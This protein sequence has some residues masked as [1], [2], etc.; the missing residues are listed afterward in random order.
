M[1]NIFVVSI[2]H[3]NSQPSNTLPKCTLKFNTLSNNITLKNVPIARTNA[4]MNIGLSQRKHAPNGMLFSWQTA[5]PRVFWMKDTWVD[6]S[7]GFFDANDVLFDIQTMQ[8]NTLQ[9]H[10]S[11]QKTKTALELPQGKFKKIGLVVGSKLAKQDCH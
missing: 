4:E 10:Y 3:A 6:L 1:L 9:Y 7:I 2:G 5:E 11:V 8:A